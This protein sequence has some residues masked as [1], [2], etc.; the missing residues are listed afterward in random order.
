MKTMAETLIDR[1]HTLAAEIKLGAVE[2]DSAS[3]LPDDLIGKFVDLELVSVLV[4]RCYGG[5]ELG[6]EA[7]CTIVRIVAEADQ[8][9]AW[10]LAFYIGHNWIHCQFPEEA[11]REIFA[12]GPSPCTAG[13][14]A[15][16]LK[17]RA[18]DGGFRVS[19]RNGWNSGSPHADWIMGSGMVIEGAGPKGP[20]SFIV[21]AADVT[22]VDTWDVQGMRATGSWDI[23]YDDVFIPTHRTVASAA[24][25]A[26]DTPGSKLHAN[27]FYSRPLI[28]VTFTYS[29]APFVGALRGASDEFIGASSIRHGT[30]DG[31]PVKEKPTVHMCAG[32]GAMNSDTAEAIFADMVRVAASTEAA[33]MDVAGRL[34]F[35]ARSAGLAT[36]C[37]VSVNDLVLGSGANAFRTESLMQRVF[38]NVNMISVHAFFDYDASMEGYGRALLGLEPNSPV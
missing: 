34:N 22:L 18:V 2:I 4:P 7:A 15:P 13:V 28:L 25:M 20:L 16:T 32:R 3:K 37:K 26:G 1:A 11:Q 24:L 23:V 30:N 31:K 6:L 12:N 38:R 21:P 5:S 14:L 36:F 10:V 35:K 27:P 33:T 29:L 17:L 8:A 19:G 9:A